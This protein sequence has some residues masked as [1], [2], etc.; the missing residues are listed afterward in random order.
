M[1]LPSSDTDKRRKPLEFK[2]SDHVHLRVS[3]TK[4]VQRF[5]V[6]RKLAPRY[7][8]PYPIAARSGPV[9]YKV[10]LPSKLADVHDVFHVSQLK[11]FLEPPIDKVLEDV[12]QLQPDDVL[13]TT[14]EDTWREGKRH[15]EEK[16]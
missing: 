9:A 6:K 1:N 3:P 13:R 15:L 10:E 16:A 7:I 5:G 11:K 12:E 8:G 2:D 4:G 14:G